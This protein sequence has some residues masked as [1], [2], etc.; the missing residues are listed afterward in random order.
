LTFSSSNSFVAWKAPAK[1]LAGSLR[2]CGLSGPA[3]PIPIEQ[4]KVRRSAASVYETSS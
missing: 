4:V 2:V 1:E 3:E